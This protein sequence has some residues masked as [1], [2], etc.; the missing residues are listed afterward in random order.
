[1]DLMIEPNAAP[2]SAPESIERFEGRKAEHIR[3]SMDPSMQTFG[4]GFDTVQLKHEALPNLDFNE[5][6][7]DFSGAVGSK[8]RSSF[9]ISAMTAGHGDSLEINRRLATAAEQ[10]SW[11][12]AV[13]SQRRELIDGA[14]SKEWKLIR[15]GCPAAVLFG[16]LGVSQLI[17]SGI[18][19]VRRL[20]D[21]LEAS[22]MV[23]HLNALQE[24]LQVEGTPNFRGGLSAIGDLV[25]GLTIPV[26][27]KETGCGI[28]QATAE[29]LLAVGVSAIDVAGFGGTHWGRIEGKRAEASRAN[30]AAAI[31]ADSAVTFKNW[32]IPTVESLEAA[33]KAV[34]T[35]SAHAGGEI[36]ASGGV[37]TGL[38]AAKALAL[39][40]TRV[41]VA[42]PLMAAALASESDDLSPL[43]QLMQRFEFELKTAMFCTGSGSVAELRGKAAR[44][45]GGTI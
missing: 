10:M 33:L 3:L 4:G 5:I 15:A 25:K 41:G 22:A 6:K 34:A 31:R 14:A 30:E 23:V 37:R 38:D 11:P 21:G 45:G 36:W 9:F 19:S 24:C 40:A 28:S 29:R 17:V 35:K 1:M 20:V 16:N 26:I 43:I 27:V 8:A 2:N 39:G 32:G 44:T 18:D 42:Q 13:G 12:L 7:T